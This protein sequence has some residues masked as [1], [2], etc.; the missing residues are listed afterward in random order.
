MLLFFFFLDD[1]SLS[2]NC[3]LQCEQVFLEKYCDRKKHHLFNVQRHSMQWYTDAHIHMHRFSSLNR[4]WK[5]HSLRIPQE[6]SNNKL[7]YHIVFICFYYQCH[8]HIT[9]AYLKDDNYPSCL[10]NFSPLFTAK[11]QKTNKQN[12]GQTSI[13]PYFPMDGMTRGRSFYP[14]GLYSI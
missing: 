11:Q 9:S 14:T 3:R 12:P 4:A 5:I 8:Y 10:N 1:G 13:F 6:L 2:L 7:Q